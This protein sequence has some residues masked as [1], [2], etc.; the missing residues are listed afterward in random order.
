MPAFPGPQS[1]RSMWSN[2]V[3]EKGNVVEKGC[4]P[5]AVSTDSTLCWCG[6]ENF[7]CDSCHFSLWIKQGVKGSLFLTNL[8]NYFQIL[9]VSVRDLLRN[10]GLNRNCLLSSV[11][12]PSAAS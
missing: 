1:M 2:E 12:A 3:Q 6:E 10:M 9:I 5:D 11:G 7:F 8:Q 4:I